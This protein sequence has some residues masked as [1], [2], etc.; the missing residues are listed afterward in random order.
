MRSTQ[1]GMDI[2][3]GDDALTFPM[4][5][6]GGKGVISVVANIVPQ[7]MAELVKSFE[8]GNIEEARKLHLK[9]FA[10]MKAMFIETNPI[11]V[12]TAMDIL[13]RI[14]G[15]L[16]LPLSPMTDENKKKL[17]GTTCLL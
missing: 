14:Q 15:D 9:M 8:E 10:L 4:M 13:G 17:P 11:P 6:L 1:G 16:R 5:A 2:L 12:K 7:D 3:S